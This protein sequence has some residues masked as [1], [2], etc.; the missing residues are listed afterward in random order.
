MTTLSVLCPTRDPGPRVRALLEPLTTVADE[1]VVAADARVLAADLADYAMV[2]D[3]LVRFEYGP[4]NSSLAWLHKQC[5]GDWVF[6]ISGDEV[7]SPALIEQLPELIR[8]RDMI[9]AWMP[10]RTVFP[11]SRHWL[12]EL[13]WSYNPIPRLLRN[14]ATAYFPGRPHSHVEPTL[15]ARWLEAP[16]YHLNCLL[17]PEAERAAKAERN[18]RDD[19]TVRTASGAEFNATWYLPERHSS[20]APVEV[21]ESDQAA[22]DAV[23]EAQPTGDAVAIDP[24]PAAKRAEI[25]LYWAARELGASAYRATLTPV[26]RDLRVYAREVRLIRFRVANDGDARWP[27]GLEQ[28]PQIRLAYR[29]LDRRGKVVVESSPRSPLPHPLGPGESCLMPLWLEG[30]E[31]PGAYELEVD[32][33]HEHVRWF[34]CGV[35]LRLDV[36]ATRRS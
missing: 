24:P 18:A 13:P 15:P 33:V 36:C 10:L 7:A 29:W 35:R 32:L 28:E 25:E 3:R 21:P 26:E 8:S 5:R 31:R 22:I 4:R 17:L 2:A 9:Q 20:L 12:D 1:V 27:W 14:D 23:L 19:N 11:D 34:D 30:P 6:L 16:M